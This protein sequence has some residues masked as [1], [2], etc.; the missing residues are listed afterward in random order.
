MLASLSK[1]NSNA[2]LV[3]FDFY[4][5]R[6]VKDLFLQPIREGPRKEV[7]S[8]TNVEVAF[9]RLK[10]GVVAQHHEGRDCVQPVSPDAKHGH[11]GNRFR[12]RAAAPQEFGVGHSVILP[13]RRRRP[14]WTRNIPHRRVKWSRI[15]LKQACAPEFLLLWRQVKWEIRLNASRAPH[16]ATANIQNILQLRRRVPRIER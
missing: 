2:A 16:T 10:E 11:P 12:R 5:R 9:G 4:N 15:F 14:V 8:P 7:I 1:D 6:T 13:K 3:V